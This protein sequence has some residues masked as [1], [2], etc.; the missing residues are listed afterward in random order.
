MTGE[1][2]DAIKGS[3]TATSE[4]AVNTGN[5]KSKNRKG[6]I[7]QGK[8]GEYAKSAPRKL[9]NNCGS[10]HHLTH[11]C[12]KDAATL[13]DVVNVNGNLHRTP[14]MERSM[15]VCSNIDCMPCKITAMS[16][17]FNLPI[18]STAKCF[19]LDD[20]ET[21]EPTEHSYQ[22]APTK[23]RHFHFLSHNG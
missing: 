19:Y 5:T 20:V 18:L 9:C 2:N 15:N 13:I 17:V 10:S 12:K 4:C 11:V 22:A 14:I 16:T 21:P 7:N 23:K 1:E 8:N 6:K 3:P